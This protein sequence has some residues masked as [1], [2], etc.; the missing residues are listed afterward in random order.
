MLGKGKVD[1][2]RVKKILD[3]ID[4]EGWVIIEG[5]V[6]EG[7]DPFQ[8]YVANNKYLRSVLNKA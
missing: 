5:A 6:P 2:A 7:A 3:E 1:F 8:S 4:Y